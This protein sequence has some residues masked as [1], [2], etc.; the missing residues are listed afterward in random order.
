MYDVFMSRIEG[1]PRVRIQ[2]IIKRTPS[3]VDLAPSHLDLV[4]ADP[5]LYT[6]KDRAVILKEALDELADRYDLILIDTPPSMGQF[7]INCLYAADHIVITLDSGA[8]A[9]N[10]ISTLT[11][12]FGDIKE[13]LGKEIHADMAIVTRWGE[14]EAPGC[15]VPDKDEKKDIFLLVRSF[16]YKTPGPTPEELKSRDKR[17]EEQ[18][19]MLAILEEIKTRFPRVFTVPFSPAVYEAQK[20]GLPVSHFAPESS[21]GKAYKTIADEV[22]TWN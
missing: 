8:F 11:T 5:F 2:D 17:R 10:G 4:G 15:P 12:I 20:R 3:G 13:D 6:L 1:F 9:L 18:G 19:R 14:G 16:F 7:V 21:A 22:M